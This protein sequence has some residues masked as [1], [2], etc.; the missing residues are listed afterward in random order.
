MSGTAPPHAAALTV[1]EG[2]PP[3]GLRALAR[4]LAP[5][6]GRLGNT[7]RL[8][9]VVCVL[10]TICEVFRVPEPA[11]A[12]FIA[13]FVSKQDA[14]TTVQGALVAGVFATLGIGLAILC[15]M[16]T[17]SEP[18][19]RIVV[20]AG[21]SFT[22]MFLSRASTLGVGFFLVGFL[23]AF[24]LTYGDQLQEIG[25]QPS[26]AADTPEGSL[27]ELAFMPPE[28]ALLHTLLWLIVA[29][30][31]PVLVVLA[32]NVVSGQDPA[33]LLRRELAARLGALAAACGGRSGAAA[34]LDAL[35]LDGTA[36]L[37]KQAELS[38]KFRRSTPRRRADAALV[39]PV[40]RLV[41]DV[42]AWR[43]VGKRP[44]ADA[45]VDRAVAVGSGPGADRTDQALAPLVPVLEAWRR[46]VLTGTG[47]IP[48]APAMEVPAVRVPSG[49]ASGDG[50][51]PGAIVPAMADAM[52][53]P[54]AVEIE[55]TLRRVAAAFRLR[56]E[57]VAKK[58]QKEKKPFTLLR[59][60]AFSNPDHARFGFKVALA[61]MIC[62]L[63]YAG[64]DWSQIHT[65][66]VT[67]FFVPQDSL[68]Q[69]LHKATLRI[70]GCLLGATLGIGTILLFMPAMTDL[71]QLLL[72]IGIVTFIGGWI[73]NG[74][75][76]TS[77]AGLQLAFAF[78]LVI[79]QG[80]GPTLDMQTG[81]DRAIGILFGIIVASTV[82]AAIWP[83]RVAAKV[84][85]GLA[86]ALE[87]L[88]E[89]VGQV[90]EPAALRPFSQ[91]VAATRDLM[92]H[93]SFERQVK[94]GN[95][96]GSIDARLLTSLQA[97]VVPVAIVLR[98]AAEERTG[99]GPAAA[100]ARAGIEGYHRA[101]SGWLRDAAGWVRERAPATRFLDTLPAPPILPPD[102][103]TASQA[104]WYVRLDSDLRAMLGRLVA[105]GA[106]RQPTASGVAVV[107]GAHV[108][109]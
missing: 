50:A 39:E 40:G 37:S 56:D 100:E 101:L 109:A 105:A 90:G 89:Q 106:A 57:A 43:R 11:V 28:E 48:Q 22:S 104:A 80:F 70:S 27:P 91:A 81:R 15:F 20:V 85:T 23:S 53:V 69:T 99:D 33:L 5:T 35:A 8:V 51:A 45:H 95:D 3:R 7:V 72:V 88:A 12:G 16:L 1:D 60:D 32:A 77:Y 107:E 108:A 10:V 17:L 52:L 9:A 68:G 30:V 73:S 94:R 103:D 74:S 13:V 61:A 75:A 19:L 66:M 87:K 24:G 42:L 65:A 76:R 31:L 36:L 26:S 47:D 82:F 97:L 38:A 59:P 49:N 93:D 96:S 62:Y 25:L 67:C 71:G 55:E 79:L 86:G 4:E 6:P 78:Y 34:G 41:V 54:L 58:E 102:G 64:A 63:S 44:D 29:A 18:A 83:E 84:R 14:A 21:I 92:V 46:A 98:L 2:D